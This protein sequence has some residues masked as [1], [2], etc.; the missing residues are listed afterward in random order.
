MTIRA[1]LFDVDGTLVDSNEAHVDAWAVAFREAGR[2]Q[3]VGDIRLQIGKGGDLLIPSLWP[4][5]KEDQRKAAA[6]AHDRH[7]KS[8]YLRHIKPFAGAREL[9]AR[10]RKSGRTIVLASSAKRA[11]VEYYLKLLDAEDLVDAITS[12]DDVD[13]S[14]PE[15]DIFEAALDKAGVD[16]D[17]A[18]AVGDTI[19]DVEA[20]RRIGIATIGLTSGPCDRA[21][22]KDAGALAVFADVADLLAGFDRSPLSD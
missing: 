17:A 11:E 7:F 6:K 22:L 20:A 18:I 4:E 10:V 9:L 19:Y 16:P 2:P 3:E 8:A 21:Q 12:A 13:A 5:A 1:V 15:P 14:K